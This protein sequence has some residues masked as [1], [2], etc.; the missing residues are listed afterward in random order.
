MG[1]P[2]LQQANYS[3]GTVVI[4]LPHYKYLDKVLRSSSYEELMWRFMEAEHPAKEI[5]ESYAAFHWMKKHCLVHKYNWLHIGDG[6]HTRTAAI[7]AFFSKTLNYSIDPALNIKKFLDWLKRYNVTGVEAYN[8]KFQD[9]SEKVIP[10]DKFYNITCVHA[11]V[12]LEEVDQHFP[13]WYYLYT[14]PCCKPHQQKFSQ[15]YLEENNISLIF[16]EQDLGILS[17]C[18]EVLI[19]R[20]NHHNESK[21]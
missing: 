21:D 5:T 17:D 8:R 20:K 2:T 18:R 15:K 19:Y 4:P 3:G 16:E 7:F 11:H 12:D 10:R 6:G 9:L 1:K 13:N 14:N